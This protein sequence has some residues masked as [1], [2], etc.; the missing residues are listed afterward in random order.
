MTK[1][2]GNA[3]RNSNNVPVVLAQISLDHP[4]KEVILGVEAKTAIETGISEGAVVLP[5]EYVNS[6]TEGD[7]VYVVEDGVL[8]R[9]EV[10]IGIMTDS[11]IEI[12]KGVSAGDLVTGNLPDGVAEGSTVVA[13]PAGTMN[14]MAVPAPEV[15]TEG[16]VTSIPVSD[17]ES[18]EK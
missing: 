9:R 4:D 17:E 5:Y 7:F 15:D 12:R 6:D 13:V 18:G 2:A 10:S 8:R 1:I 16:A 14:G 11:M 3:T